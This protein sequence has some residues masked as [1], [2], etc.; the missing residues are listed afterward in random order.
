MEIACYN[1]RVGQDRLTSR[2][3]A[4]ASLWR[5]VFGWHHGRLAEQIR[6]DKIDILFD[7]AGH[8][9]HN[10]MLTFVRK[11]APIQITWI[12]YEGTTG[13][14][15]IDYLLADR[16]MVPEAAESHYR[17]KVL[18]LPDSYLCFDPPEDA[19]AVSTLPAMRSGYVTFGS[20]NN[21]AKI[22]GEVIA[23]WAIS[24]AVCRGPGCC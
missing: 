13:L 6:D 1:D 8:T 18:R 11:P 10:R 23:A 20:C 24:F 16:H 7:L 17:E 19:P 12:G 15:A 2:I 3:Q 5:D 21:L 4:A 9:A 22:N 14:S